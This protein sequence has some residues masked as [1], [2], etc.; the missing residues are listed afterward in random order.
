MIFQDALTALHPFYT[1][2][3]QISEGYRIHHKVSKSEAQ[4]ARDRDARPGRHPAGRTAASTTIPHQFSGGMRQRAMIAMALVNDPQLLIADEPTTA[5]DVTVQ[6]QILDLLQDL[7]REFN[8]AV[9]II[10]H[11]LGVVA[12]MADDEMVMYA[13][14]AVEYGAD[15]RD[16]DPPRDALH[17]GPAGQRPGRRRRRRR[18]AD[19]DPRHPAEPAQPA[20][21]VRVPPPVPARRQGA[22]RPVPDHAARAAA[23]RARR[24][25]RQALPPGQ[26]RARST[27]RRSCPRSRRI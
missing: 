11:D 27:P 19:P 7:Q 1:I 9:I 4:E 5:L 17:L 26:P 13:G 15:P 10:T 25:P 21:R 6:A 2:G 16:P 24:E 8:S 22:R 23:G 12:E 14:R 18:P 20:D 3:D